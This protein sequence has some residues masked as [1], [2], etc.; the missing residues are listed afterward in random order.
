MRPDGTEQR[1]LTDTDYNGSP[2][3]SGNGRHV[4]FTSNRTGSLQLWRMGLDGSNQVQLTNGS[5]VQAPAISPDGRWIVYNSVDRWHLWKVSIDGGDPVRLVDGLAKYPSISPDGKWIACF[6]RDQ[7]QKP[8]IMVVPLGG[9]RAA[10]DFDV[11]PRRLAAPRLHWSADGKAVIYAATRDG[12]ASLYKQSLNGGSPHRFLDLY[13]SDIFDFG[14]S[15]DGQ[16]LAAVR[17]KWNHD[18]VLIR[19]FNQE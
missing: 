15:P 17:G 10:K 11:S 4:V 12:S 9:G 16:H 8:R 18:V 1:Q 13:E 3:V 7:R 5:G 6:G 14:L 19:G 2:V